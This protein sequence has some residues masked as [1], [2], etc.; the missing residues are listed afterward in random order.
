MRP[1]VLYGKWKLAGYGPP[2]LPDLPPGTGQLPRHT[3]GTLGWLG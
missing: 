1:D 2:W 3:V